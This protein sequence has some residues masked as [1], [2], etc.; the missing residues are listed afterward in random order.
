[1]ETCMRPPFSRR[2]RGFTLLEVLIA[3]LIFSLGL[4]GLAGLMVVSVKTNQSAYLRTQ[5]SFLAQSMA[6]RM[7]AN[8]AVIDEYEGDYH[9]GTA[10]NATCETTACDPTALAANDRAVWSRQLV[11]QM[12]DNATASI[13]CDGASLG[14]PQTAG[15]ATYDGLC[16]FIIE[17]SEARL[18]SSD[19]PAELVEEQRFAWAFQP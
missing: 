15:A 18:E 14:A 1:M 2:P 7:R 3:L 9:I 19:D 11:T 8:I 6:D 16:M 10:G 17:W 4:L 12:P 13:Q 5:A